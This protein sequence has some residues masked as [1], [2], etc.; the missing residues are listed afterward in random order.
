MEKMELTEAIQIAEL[1]A[2][3]YAKRL[4]KIL[5]Q[6]SP[7]STRTFIGRGTLDRTIFVEPIFEP[8]STFDERDAVRVALGR[9]FGY[10]NGMDL[11]EW[12]IAGPFKRVWFL[13]AASGWSHEQIAEVWSEQQGIEYAY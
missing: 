7:V 9:V 2:K 3:E 11:S 4:R 6:R 1:P 12:T 8:N 10:T 5:V 13:L